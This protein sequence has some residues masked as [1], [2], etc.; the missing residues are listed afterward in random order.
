MSGAQHFKPSLPSTIAIVARSTKRCAR[1]SVYGFSL[2]RSLHSRIAAPP[3][4]KP[5]PFVPDVQTFLTL[6]GRGLSQHAAKIE[7]WDTLF[8]L[9]SAQ[10]RDLGVEPARSR[11]YLLRWREKFRQGEYGVGGDAKHVSESG[12]VECRLVEM[13][14]EDQTNVSASASL[15]QSP[16]MGK[17]VLNVPWT[18]PKAH[19]AAAP[20]RVANTEPEVETN[21]N[22]GEAS[23]ENKDETPQEMVETPS[24]NI[25][26][27]KQLDYASLRR[28]H[29]LSRVRFKPGRGILGP[30]VKPVKNTRGQIGIVDVNEGMWEHRRGHKVDGGER[31]KAEVRFKRRVV[32]RRAARK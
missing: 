6:I 3:I 26:G 2:R 15:S 11:K 10:L 5:T 32:E 17:Q 30:H 7:S 24:N 25:E 31:R 23:T 4:P 19:L 27:P 12:A 14:K 9:S 1:T 29:P 16:G 13:S 22:V 18:D 28:A 20:E 21:E 8:R